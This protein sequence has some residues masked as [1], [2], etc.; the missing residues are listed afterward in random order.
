MLW[1]ISVNNFNV[2]CLFFAF[3]RSLLASLYLEHLHPFHHN[4]FLHLCCLISSSSL[5]CS[6]CKSRV[7]RMTAVSTFLQSAISPIILF[8]FNSN[9]YFLVSHHVLSLLNFPLLSNSLDYSFLNNV[10]W[11]CHW[12]KRRQHHCTL[13]CLCMKW[14]IDVQWSII[15]WLWKEWHDWSLIMR[16]ISCLH[17]DFWL[18]GKE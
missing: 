10:A 14:I 6:G 17:G 2:K 4:H 3:W 9:F 1:S 8:A 7:S 12:K 18:K 15:D 16:H 13:L 11:V 5:S